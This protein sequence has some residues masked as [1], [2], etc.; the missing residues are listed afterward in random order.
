MPAEELKKTLEDFNL[1]LIGAHIIPDDK[2][3]ISTIYQ[4]KDCMMR[5]IEYA[6]KAGMPYLSLPIDLFPSKS[7]LMSRCEVYNLSLIHILID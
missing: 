6:A 3:K 4:D 2:T 5:N 1:K 7:Y